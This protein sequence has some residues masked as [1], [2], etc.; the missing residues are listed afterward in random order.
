VALSGGE[1]YELLFTVAQEDYDKIKGNPNLSVIGHM[2]DKGSGARMI[3]RGGD[4][5]PLTAQGWNAFGT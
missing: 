2:A 4:S 1:D 5:I 3:G